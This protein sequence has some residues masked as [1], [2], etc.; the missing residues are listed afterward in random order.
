MSCITLPGQGHWED[1][2]TRTDSCPDS[3]CLTSIPIIVRHDKED[4]C[5]S[6]LNYVA[7]PLRRNELSWA[8]LTCE[9]FFSLGHSLTTWCDLVA[10]RD[11]Q[12]FSIVGKLWW[13]LGEVLPWP[14]T[15]HLGY[16]TEA[17]IWTQN[18]KASNELQDVRD[19]VPAPIQ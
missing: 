5:C 6:G 19:R 11:I 4:K 10:V 12:T 16:K 3:T 8:R 13:G 7:G 14:P 2:H 17:A 1:V 15:T 9:M 18:P